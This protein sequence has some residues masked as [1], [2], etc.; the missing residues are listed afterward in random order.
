MGK[1]KIEE[2]GKKLENNAKSVNSLFSFRVVLVLDMT[3]LNVELFKIEVDENV[4]VYAPKVLQTMIPKPRRESH[5][6]TQKSQSFHISSQN[7]QYRVTADSVHLCKGIIN[8][9]A[10]EGGERVIR[11]VKLDM[12][13]PIFSF[14][15]FDFNGIQ[16][17][18]TLT[19]VCEKQQGWTGQTDYLVSV[20]VF[21]QQNVVDKEQKQLQTPETAS[22]YWFCRSGRPQCLGSPN[23][24]LWKKHPVLHLSSL[25][26]LRNVRTGLKNFKG[27]ISDCAGN[28]SDDVSQSLSTVEVFRVAGARN[29]RCTTCPS[30]FAA[31]EKVDSKQHGRATKL[32]DRCGWVA[33]E[34]GSPV[35]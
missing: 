18:Y 26:L 3:D 5:Q 6:H 10:A 13:S 24:E 29:K 22:D 14:P 23:P 30:S 25:E 34:T 20:Y 19:R 1:E 27:E 35:Q 7:D 2:T 8:S 15:A 9:V 4:A 12:E 32:L 28:K 33:F 16:L 11:N 31:V 17:C 21:H